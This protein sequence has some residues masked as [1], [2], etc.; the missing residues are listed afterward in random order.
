[1]TPRDGGG[2]FPQRR[3]RLADPTRSVLFAGFKNG[4]R[5]LAGTRFRRDGQEPARI[6][7]LFLNRV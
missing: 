4:G 5:R 6:P 1:M 2:T 3:V 7:S